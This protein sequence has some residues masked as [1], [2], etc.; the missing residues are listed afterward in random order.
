MATSRRV[1]GF[2]VKAG[3]EV[4]RRKRTFLALETLATFLPQTFPKE[5]QS[6]FQQL[7]N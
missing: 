5:E 1:S 4:A 7:C 3:D 2:G 6:C